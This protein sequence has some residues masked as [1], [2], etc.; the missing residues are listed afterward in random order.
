MERDPAK[1]TR[2]FIFGQQLRRQRCTR[3]VGRKWRTVPSRRSLSASCLFRN[4]SSSSCFTS[5]HFIAALRILLQ[6]RE[7]KSSSLLD[8]PEALPCLLRDSLLLGEGVAPQ[9]HLPAGIAIHHHRTR[10]PL[11]PP[12]A[13]AASFTPSSCHRL[14]ELGVGLRPLVAWSNRPTSVCAAHRRLAP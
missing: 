8:F 11:L 9:V 14:H 13:M 5:V 3:G 7:Q 12:I 10:T 6:K 1:L 4:P 2:W